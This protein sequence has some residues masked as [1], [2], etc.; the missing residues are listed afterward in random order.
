[1]THRFL[2]ALIVF[3]CTVAT[4]PGRAYRLAVVIDGRA[5]AAAGA[6][7]TAERVRRSGR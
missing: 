7:G 2:G 5:A 3:F 6:N 1:M 4:T